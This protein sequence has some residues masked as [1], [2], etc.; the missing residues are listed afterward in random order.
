MLELLN[1][2]FNWYLYLDVIESPEALGE[3]PKVLYVTCECGECIL[4]GPC[5]S[6]DRSIVIAFSAYF[7]YLLL[8]YTRICDRHMQAYVDDLLH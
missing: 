2:K 3:A 5:C 8:E 7:V 4:D 6:V 1:L